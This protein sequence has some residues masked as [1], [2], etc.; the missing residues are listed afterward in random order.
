[1]IKKSC[2]FIDEYDTPFIEAHVGG[3][4][5]EIKNGLASMLHNALKTS[6]SLQYAMLTGIFLVI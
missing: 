4:Y 2:F 6:R 3:F 1:M 5:R